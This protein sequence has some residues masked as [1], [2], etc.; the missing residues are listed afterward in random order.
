MA[1]VSSL[2]GSGH[3]W[4]G[5]WITGGKQAPAIHLPRSRS[6]ER[7]F[8]LEHL[9]DN[10]GMA[11]QAGAVDTPVRGAHEAAPAADGPAHVYPR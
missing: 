7:H 9:P 1:K 2:C 4:V 10:L 11:Q 3:R 6:P 8:K 5:R